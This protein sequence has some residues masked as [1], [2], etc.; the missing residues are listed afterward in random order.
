LRAASIVLGPTVNIQRVG[1]LL[2]AHFFR[3]TDAWILYKSPLGGR[4]CINPTYRRMLTARVQSFESFS[5]DPTL[6]GQIAS[7]YVGGLQQGG[8]GA[9]IK[10]LV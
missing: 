10:H 4:V 3:S 7:A 8:V 1:R 9:C 5:E 2:L 6:S